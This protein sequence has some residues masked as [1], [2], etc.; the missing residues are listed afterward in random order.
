ML[1]N[2]F[3]NKANRELRKSKKEYF[4]QYFEDNKN[5]IK[6]TWIS[7]KNINTKAIITP[8]TSQILVNGKIIHDPVDIAN[9]KNDFF[10]NIGHNIDKDIPRNNK[11]PDTF[12][13]SRNNFN[14]LI[15][16]V[17]NEELIYIIKSFDSN[18]SSG[19]SS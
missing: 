8:K 19:P 4:N 13:K 3:R 11:S 14:F 5:D 12:L 2:K 10:V 18:K 16:F 7:I 17:T 6:K 15:T 9:C 1:Y